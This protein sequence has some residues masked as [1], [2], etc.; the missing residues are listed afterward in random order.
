[1]EIINALLLTRKDL[2]KKSEN[3]SFDDINHMDFNC[4]QDYKKYN[5]SIFVDDYGQTKVLKNRYGD[6]G[7]VISYKKQEFIPTIS[8][9]FIPKTVK[10]NNSIKTSKLRNFIHTCKY[11]SFVTKGK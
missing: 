3:K 9:V 7:N 2:I 6:G 8:K 10:I 5:L 1:M 4:Y 11:N